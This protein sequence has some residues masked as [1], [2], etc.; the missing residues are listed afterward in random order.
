M[1]FDNQIVFEI[2]NLPLAEYSRS[3][4]VNPNESCQKIIK[5]KLIGKEV[6]FQYPALAHQL[7]NMA[8]RN[9]KPGVK[10][11]LT[12]TRCSRQKFETGD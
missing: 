5:S 11:P 10:Q 3:E 2:F 8:G 12:L 9:W 1:P 6:N 7:E 4:N